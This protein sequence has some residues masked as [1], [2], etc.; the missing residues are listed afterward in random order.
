MRGVDLPERIAVLNKDNKFMSYTH[1]ARVRKLLKQQ[2]AEVFSND[3]FT[4]KLKG[5]RGKVMKP[6]ITNFTNY[7]S[8]EERDVYVQNLSNTQ[9]SIQFEVGPGRYESVLVPKTRRPLNL[10]QHIPFEAIKRSTDIR[11]LV[12]RRPPA[13]QLMTEAEYTKF[14]E[15]LATAMKTS[16]EEE[17]TKSLE[18]QAQLM[19]RRIP[20][21]KTE[22]E[23]PKT[24]DQV[25]QE[26]LENPEE[27][28]EAQPLP[29]VVGL[30]AQVGADVSQGAKLKAGDMMAELEGM[31][32][33]LRPTDFEYLTSMGYYKVIKKWASA[34]MVGEA[35]SEEEG[36][37]DL[38]DE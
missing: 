14:Y 38:Q 23:K 8:G 1:P 18:L 34:R 2:K 26:R 19:D 4:I 37:E 11:K 30:C 9:V 15:D 6:M 27:A 29:Q 28:A 16:V 20:V 25:E 32:G 17:I 33:E 22:E 3:P 24:I 35:S 36:E 13:L 7:F 10:T 5:E 12:N 31:E 21:A